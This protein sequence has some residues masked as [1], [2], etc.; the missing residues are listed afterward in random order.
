M[1]RLSVL[2]TTMHQTDFS[3]FKEMNIRSDVVFS[4]QCDR[5]EVMQT[6]ID[7]HRVRMI[8]TTTKGVGR[9]RTIGL[10]AADTEIVLFADDDIVYADDYVEQVLRAF[11]ELPQADVIAFSLDITKNG[12]IV[13]QSYNR[14]R[15]I[16]TWNCLRYGACVLAAR[17]KSLLK[18]NLSFTTLFGGGSM[19]G[20][21]EDSLFVLDCIRG[22]LKMYSH[23][24]VLGKCAADVSS[25][26]TG[27]HEKFFYDKGAWLG[28][29]FP[30]TGCLLKHYFVYH[31]R[32][33]TKLSYRECC[34]LMKRGQK[35]YRTLRAWERES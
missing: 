19:Y 34:R 12:E 6:Q 9:N 20:C 28:A 23:S 29:A 30:K 33:E 7:G 27:Y 15:R 1:E 31:F 8:S 11:D 21:G 32:K 14:T 5:D 35:G 25:W 2:C 17:T 26:F 13:K 10:L 22:G 24:Y 3:K 18:A 16:H 4:N